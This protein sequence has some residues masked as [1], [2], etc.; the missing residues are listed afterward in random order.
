MNTETKVLKGAVSNDKN[1]NN[2]PLSIVL[3][4]F[5]PPDDW[6]THL[7]IAYQYIYDCLGFHPEVIIV[8]DGSAPPSDEK[9]MHLKQAIPDFH[10]LSYPE[11]KGKGAALRYGI[12]RTKGEKIIFTDIDFPYTVESFI[13][14]WNT[15]AS[16]DVAIGVKDKNYYQHVPKIRIF[17]SKIL[18]KLIGIL[19][20]IPITDTQ[21]GLKGFNQKGKNIF[22][23]TTIDR[24]L[25][26]LEFIYL[27]FQQKP[28]VKIT[29]REIS[30]RPEVKFSKM[31]TKILL[32][33]AF[34][35]LNI[36]FGRKHKKQIKK[37]EAQK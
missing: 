33:E 13:E 37:D 31:N 16:Q 30:L 29:S 18:R 26:D 23:Q 11:N 15:L 7:E 4:Y 6:N 24:Y 2:L 1:P 34:N 36:A 10:F 5:R 8:N 19:F 27:C 22:L 12:Y 17:V 25:C 21:C 35:L 14:I 9:L 28:S 32:A 3:P 20:H